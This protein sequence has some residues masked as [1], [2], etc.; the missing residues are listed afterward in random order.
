[1][2]IWNNLKDF[3]KVVPDD[4]LKLLKGMYGLKQS[5][6]IWHKKLDKELQ[7][8]GFNKMKCDHSIWIYQKDGIKVIIPV[9]V[10][11]MTIMSKSK[12]AVQGV[13][14]ELKKKFKLRDRKSVV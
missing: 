5:G 1:M 8:M 9:F 3:T 10:D 4:Y 7:D 14:D 6:R 12:D 2:F 13:K 11:D